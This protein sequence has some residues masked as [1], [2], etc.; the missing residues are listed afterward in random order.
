MRRLITDV[1][2]M[3]SLA[4]LAC[5]GQ[6]GTT[7]DASSPDIF[8]NDTALF[9]SAQPDTTPPCT[10]GIYEVASPVDAPYTVIVGAR[11]VYWTT[12]VLHGL[13]EIHRAPRTGGASE[14]VTSTVNELAGL[15]LDEEGTV[16]WAES[17]IGVRGGALRARTESGEART[18]Y[19]VN[20]GDWI[21]PFAIAV[22]AT[23]VYWLIH[24][25]D[26]FTDTI[27]RAPREGGGVPSEI[28][29]VDLPFQTTARRMF[30]AGDSLYWGYAAGRVLSM[31]RE[32]G[33]VAEVLHDPA[34]LGDFDVEGDTL[35]YIADD[36]SILRTPSSGGDAEVLAA[37]ENARFGIR[38]HAGTLFASTADD[39]LIALPAAGGAVTTVVESGA[40]GTASIV[41]DDDY[42]FWSN[43]ATKEAGGGVFRVCAP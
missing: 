40:I 9:D 19:S 26:S 17:V 38:F 39:R 1:A 27:Y 10:P 43:S 32:G 8:S 30:L 37:D 4:G 42:L 11:W 2:I 35:F 14:L 18:L 25:T 28:G 21:D 13:K 23:H 36:G 22:D 15:A 29:S 12:A 6:S 24:D 5:D 20:T 34:G 7:S 31:P 41:L 16:Y 3:L 33:M